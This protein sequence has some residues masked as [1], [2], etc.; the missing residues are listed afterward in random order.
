MK[1]SKPEGMQFQNT[2]NLGSPEAKEPQGEPLNDND[3]QA[4]LIVR[5]RH[6]YE[7]HVVPHRRR[8]AFAE[9]LAEIA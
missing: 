3:G 6:C 2:S 9:V 8:S 5:A 1:H 4:A 7:A